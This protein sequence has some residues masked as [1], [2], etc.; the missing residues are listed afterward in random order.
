MS[1]RTRIAV[2]AA[3]AVAAL[4]ATGLV[5]YS[6]EPAPA[7]TGVCCERTGVPDSC[8]FFPEIAACPSGY[9]EVD[10]P[11]IPGSSIDP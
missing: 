2:A 6:P 8:V 9:T 5:V 4:G 7:M 10:C 3:V 11:C 1:L